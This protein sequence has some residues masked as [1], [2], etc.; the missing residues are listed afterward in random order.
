MALGEY[1]HSANLFLSRNPV[2]SSAGAKPSAQG[3]FR[4]RYLLNLDLHVTLNVKTDTVV[5]IDLTLSLVVYPEENCEVRAFK[6][7]R[8]FARDFWRVAS[9]PILCVVARVRVDSYKVAQASWARLN[10]GL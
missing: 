7:G 1:L 2:I 8:R 3:T 9:A 10:P 4:H 5:R 6:F